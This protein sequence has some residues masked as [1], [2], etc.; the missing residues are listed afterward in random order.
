M[1]LLTKRSDDRSVVLTP[2]RDFLR[3]EAAGGVALLVA[4]AVAL[5][6]ANS[7]WQDSYVELWDTVLSIELGDWGIS[8]DL[9]EW[10]N[11]GLMAIFFFVVGL[12]IKRELVDGDLREPRR[13]AL[14]AIAAAGG[15][16]VPALLF[17]AVNASGDGSSGWA[18][19]MAT[20]IAIAVGVVSLLGARVA[21]SLKVFLLTL[22]I[23][24]DIGAIAVI[25]IVYPDDLDAG[26]IA[27]AAALVIVVIAARRL[28]VQSVLLI[29]AVG[30]ALWLALQESG[31]HAT[32]TGVFLGLM[33]PSRPLRQHDL[34]D[35]D[36]LTDLS[37][38]E[39]AH[40][41]MV[42]AR[43][44]VSVVEWLEHVL[45]PWTSFVIVPLFA[46]A[47][48]GVPVT[49]GALTDSLS[50]P[51]TYGIVVGLVV[52]KPVGIVLFAWVAVRLG[53]GELPVGGS[54]RGIAG[55][56]AVAG[57]GF[58]VSLFVTGLAF[59]DVALQD[60]AKI[61]ILLAS[62]IAAIVGSAVLRRRE[63]PPSR[64]RTVS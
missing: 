46:L 37:S 43:Q 59:D 44:S 14:P 9:Q 1:G 3:T 25:A 57:I 15:M 64:G 42:I 61:G 45:H 16:I 30:A 27:V 31:I 4:A 29:T 12:E 51:I 10:I 11:E 22:A 24:D 41:T 19:P 39:A 40:R 7:P 2:L 63:R 62:T 56:G 34:I 36:E 28:Q 48:A 38:V 49:G 13:A 23:V 50:S 53:L 8:L 21:P 18:I 5:V 26:A 58:T 20:D 55:I 35:A 6:W 17:L 33:T 60:E 32:L 47:N 54:W 52:G